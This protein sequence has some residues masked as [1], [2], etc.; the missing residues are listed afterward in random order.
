ML[1]V[2]PQLCV[3]RMKLGDRD[4]VPPGGPF[5]FGSLSALTGQRTRLHGS[6]E[7]MGSSGGGMPSQT[8]AH[9]TLEQS[10][11]LAQIAVLKGVAEA[12]SRSLCMLRAQSASG[13]SSPAR[14]QWWRLAEGHPS[15]G[16]RSGRDSNRS[17]GH[18]RGRLS[19]RC[20]VLPI[21]RWHQHTTAPQA[22]NGE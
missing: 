12:L 9:A 11:V 7:V 2:L 1:I 4:R 22:L 13:P 3:Q 14:R 21:A 15:I 5:D 17:R 6:G 18:I 8:D 16:W 10:D 19:P 20:D